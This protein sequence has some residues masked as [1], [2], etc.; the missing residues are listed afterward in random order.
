MKT[1]YE[2]SVRLLCVISCTFV[3]IWHAR[4]NTVS[5]V[6]YVCSPTYVCHVRIRLLHSAIC[7]FPWPIQI[8]DDRGLTADG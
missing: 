3:Q 6:K 8:G 1:G 4:A 7:R 2:V 5:T